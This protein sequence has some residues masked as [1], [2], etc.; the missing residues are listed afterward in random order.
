MLDRLG[1]EVTLLVD[2]ARHG[3]P[4]ARVGGASGRTVRESV[5]HVGDVCED[6]LSWLGVDEDDAA[7]WA[8]GE[9]SDVEALSRRVTDR[10]ADL[11]AE[12]RRRPPD[13]PCPTWW[14]GDHTTRFWLR[15]ALHAALV[16]RTDVETAVWHAHA[17]VDAV[18]ALDGIDEV[19]RAWL[20]HRLHAL[21][22]VPQSTWV[23]RVQAGGE[24]WLVSAEACG[25]GVHRDDAGGS[26]DATLSGT[27][28]HVYLWLWGRLPD[29]MVTTAGDHH[30]IAQLWSL[31]RIATR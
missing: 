30:V 27:P 6:A 5:R 11:L 4:E 16:H 9:G 28:Q 29:R 13:D 12:L 26:V 21:G 31:L 25:I 15:R 18:L 22:V 17:T 10:S 3:V 14:P 19:L 23:A 1:I 8:S 24:A 20:A 7:R 2:A